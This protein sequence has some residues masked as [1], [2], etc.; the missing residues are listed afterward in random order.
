MTDHT[1]TQDCIDADTIE[2]TG[3]TRTD[4]TGEA[5]V[6]HAECWVCGHPFSY[7]YV[8]DG[9]FDEETNERV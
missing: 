6:I 4:G 7:V 1:T 8:Y 9:M 3:E 2:V 5:H